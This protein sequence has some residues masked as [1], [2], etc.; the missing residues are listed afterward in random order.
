[1]FSGIV[2]ATGTITEIQSDGSNRIFWVDSRISSELKPD[3]SVCHDGVCLTV[4]E[5]IGNRHKVTAI[6]ETLEKTNLGEC[7]EGR[8]VNVERCL[9]AT[10]RID[11]HLV[12]GHVDTTGICT[13]IKVREGSYEYVFGFPK[14]FAALIIEKGSVSLNGISLTSFKVKRKS[15]RV[16]IV[17]YTFEHTN[18]KEVKKGD[19]VNI[20]FDIM[21]K[22]LLRKLSLTES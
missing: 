19:T 6:R 9:R 10:D 18:I 2:E 7:T 20:E 4:E 3:Q 17:P 15:F 11:G 12:Q 1:M 5:V 22:Y 8:T 16:A 14:K 13:S 21:G